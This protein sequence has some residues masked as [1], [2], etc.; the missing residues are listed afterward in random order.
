MLGGSMIA[1]ATAEGGGAVAFPVLTLVCNVEP[2][3]ARDFTMMIQSVGMTAASIAILTMGLP[4][5]WRSI[6]C[7]LAG[8]SLGLLL[9][10]HVVAPLLPPPFAKMF[11]VSFWLAFAVVLYWV[12][13]E[14]DRLV[15]PRIPHFAT[16]QAILLVLAG[17]IGGIVSGIAG[18]GLDITA[19]SLLVLGFRVCESVATRSSVLMMAA[20]SLI[21]FADRGLSGTISPD[22]WRYWW[23]GM[24]VVIAGAPLGAWLVSKQPRHVFAWVLYATI[25]TQFIAALLIVPQ[26]PTLLLFSGA[27]LA[28]G[29][30]TFWAWRNMARCGGSSGFWFWFWLLV[31]GLGSRRRAACLLRRRRTSPRG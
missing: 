25:S 21:G 9:G 4:V 22:A 26:S 15:H 27:A 3:V 18:C 31:L 17:V 23:V 28:L 12:N 24:P 29:L 8:G 6:L 14:G 11:F 16:R 13:R 1:G 19:F 5:E 2:I 10:L 7:S 30:G 20:A